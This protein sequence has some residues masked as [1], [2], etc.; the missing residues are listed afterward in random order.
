MQHMQHINQQNKF[1]S[2]L[3]EAILSL[4]FS[5]LLLIICALNYHCF[6]HIQEHLRQERT[7]IKV[8]LYLQF[9]CFHFPPPSSWELVKS[10][11][12]PGDG[13]QIKIFLLFSSVCSWGSL[14]IPCIYLPCIRLYL[15][16]KLVFSLITT[17]GSAHR[18]VIF[19]S[20]SKEWSSLN[21]EAEHTEKNNGSSHDYL[22]MH[23]ATATL[24]DLKA[25]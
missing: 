8:Q 1:N 7:C 19:I 10:S 24:Q 18:S 17:G 12:K 2:W 14:Y 22:F 3:I 25:I 21:W 4:D 6:G 16:S 20:S 15:C 5:L 13:F 11:V 9:F 23:S